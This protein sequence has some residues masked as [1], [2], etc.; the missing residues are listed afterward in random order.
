MFQQ[1]RI[2]CF[3]LWDI[4][5]RSLCGQ[6]TINYAS[7]SGLVTDPSGAV[8]AGAEITAR[9]TDTN[10]A[11]M[12]RTS[13]DGRFRFSYLRIG[14]YEISVHQAGFAEAVRQEA[15]RHLT[16]TVGAAFDIPF[17]LAI[18]SLETS[19]SVGVEAAPLETA[20]TEIAGT[21]VQQEIRSLPLNGRNYLNLAFLI[22]GVSPTNT[23]SNQLFAER[24]PRF[25]ARACPQAASVTF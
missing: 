24:P 1:H 8:I 2:A 7:I 23:A 3:S 15:V 19:V 9:Q 20:R 13:V 6:A 14:P 16:L 10:L 4:V 17:S 21:V 22:P 11:T 18:A 12:T 25:R 5:A